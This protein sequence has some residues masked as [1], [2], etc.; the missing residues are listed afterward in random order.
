MARK[1]LIACNGCGTIEEARLNGSI[2]RPPRGWFTVK[3]NWPHLP[4]LE[5]DEEWLICS[6]KCFTTLAEITAEAAEA[7][8]G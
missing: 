4:I 2:M 8:T 6:P 1:S 5:D 3:V 7:R